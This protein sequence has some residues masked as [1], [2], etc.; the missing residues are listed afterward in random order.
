M[1]II[2]LQYLENQNAESLGIT[3]KETF[4][5]LLPDDVHPHD[6]I[7]IVASSG[8]KFQAILR[9][10]TDVDIAYFNNGGILNY[11]IRK[12]IE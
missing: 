8:V 11:M 6:K 12:M 2:P 7:D 1:G 5:I 3:G 9:F 4:D 10:D